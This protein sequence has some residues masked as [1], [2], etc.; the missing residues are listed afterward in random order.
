MNNLFCQELDVKNTYGS[1]RLPAA[2]SLAVMLAAC[3]GGGGGGVPQTPPPPPPPPTACTTF[4][5]VADANV[6]AGKTAGASALSCGAPLTSVV[7]T[8]VSGPQVTLAAARMPTVGFE[9]SIAGT[10][11]L[12]ADV[13]LAN[14]TQATATTDIVVAPPTTNSYLTL[15]LD[16]SLR[17]GT[18]TSIRAWPVLRN[19]ETVTNITWTQV[20]GPTVQM[21]T[22]D[23]NV[24]MFTAPALSAVPNDIALKFRA[25]MTTSSGRSDSDEV[26]VSVDRQAA[27]HSNEN[28]VIFD[29]TARV[30]PYRQ[31]GIYAG[32]LARCTYDV[33]LYFVTSSDQ[34]LCSANT[35]P[36]LEA[37][38]GA[39][40]VPTVEQV[41]GRVLVSHDFLGANFES[42][43]R[44]QDTSGDFR[45][46]LKGVTSIVLGSHVR[47]SFYTSVTGAIYLDAANLWLTPEQRDVVTEVPDFRSSFD[48]QLQFTGVGRLVVNNDYAR[49]SYAPT[50]RATRPAAEL[51]FGLGRLMYHELAHAGD[52]FSPFNRTL[53]GSQSMWLNV[54]PRLQNG[55]LPSDDLAAAYPLTS[56]VMKGLGRVM[57]QGATPT[58]D[59]I[60]LTAAQVGNAFGSDVASD[61]Y[62]YS[63]QV[64]TN[65][66]E[67]LA[68]LFEEFMM[69][70]NHGARADVAYTNV[71]TEG[72]TSEQLIV[73][74]GQ[75]GR[76]GHASIKPRVKL[77]VARIAPW[78]AATE[79][80]A[81]PA[82]IQM[83]AGASWE[84]NLVLGGGLGGANPRPSDYMKTTAAKVTRVRDDMASRRH[85]H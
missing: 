69:Y 45:R 73:A 41:M 3:G 8:A 34:N 24:M 59:Q 9:T 29:R 49:A 42:F 38:V 17:P 28:A 53:N 83:T 43:L 80:D 2:I 62:A 7:W 64:N 39:S 82:P 54:V 71:F 35:L 79:V 37:E 1:L 78:I 22:E 18:D 15:R 77:V 44:L 23:R 81:L 57:Y 56:E 52:F 60:Q 72:M 21:N 27:P 76:V 85:A 14:G 20:A 4:E 74:W 11:R 47:P 66:R 12:R 40:A 61:D 26:I 13:V 58:P 55:T 36:L 10:V 6:V 16:H 68:M 67:D 70:R 51:V 32:V 25:T 31:A 33:S 84:A 63:A 46:L 65:S 48:D 30:Y 19:G 50:E 75:R 5:I